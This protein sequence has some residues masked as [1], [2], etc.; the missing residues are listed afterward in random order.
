MKCLA[1][2]MILAGSLFAQTKQIPETAATT[3]PPTI[4]IGIDLQL[5]MS[6]DAIISRLAAR[7]KV[8][9]I[10][11][12]DDEWIVE[13]KENPQPTIGHLGFTAG[14]LIYASRLW[15][16]GQGDSYT[17][18]RALWDAMSQV[19]KGDQHTCVFEAPVGRSPTAETSY[20]RLYCGPKKIDIMAVNVLDGNGEKHYT[21]ISEVL[22]S[23]DGR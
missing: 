16:Q 10:H 4:N 13:E 22:S 1:V 8:A 6:R 2:A 19:E 23:E 5:G 7:Y 20:M 21:S 17:F 12:D 9:K 14:K 18:A 11:G 15:T 3:K